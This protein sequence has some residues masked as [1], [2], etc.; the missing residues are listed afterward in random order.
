MKGSAVPSDDCVFGP[1]QVE[2]FKCSS[3]PSLWLGW[4][5]R[6]RVFCFYFQRFGEKFC[7]GCQWASSELPVGRTNRLRKPPPQRAFLKM[8]VRHSF[9][10]QA[11]ID[12]LCRGETGGRVWTSPA[13]II[14]SLHN[15]FW[16]VLC[17]QPITTLEKSSKKHCLKI[18]A[19]VAIF[20][21]FRDALN[22]PAQQSGTTINT[23]DCQCGGTR[24]HEME[25]WA[26]PDLVC[27]FPVMTVWFS[28][29]L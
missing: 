9:S 16:H 18:C 17:E 14:H 22:P 13:L 20:L 7:S 26:Q 5:N 4:N 8:A 27:Y 24:S 19:S 11:M 1:T 25:V 12:Q 23:S 15:R 28:H 21:S 10:R 6:L 3:T 2:I 29:L